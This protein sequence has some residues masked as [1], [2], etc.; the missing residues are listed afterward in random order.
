MKGVILAGG[1]GTR[2][3]LLTRVTNKHLLP[4]YDKPMILHPL[5]KLLDAGIKDILIVSGP[6]HS[7]HFLRLLGSGKDYKA[8]FTYELQDEAGGIAQAVGLAEDFADG[9]NIAVIL[10][11]NIF[12]ADFTKAIKSFKCGAKVFLKKTSDAKRFGVAEIRNG[13]IVSIEEKPKKPKSNYAVTGMY[14]YDSKI[15]DIVKTLKPSARGELEI[16]DVNNKYIEMGLM[17]YSII[18]G[19][20]TDAGTY[21]SLLKA[22]LLVKNAAKKNKNA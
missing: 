10:G 19:F 3:N 1:F 7:G 13:K 5:Q 18:K 8:R 15:F 16:T 4:V 9:E 6:E 11:D 20:W 22:S 17:Q 21:D 2:L 14:L 12:E